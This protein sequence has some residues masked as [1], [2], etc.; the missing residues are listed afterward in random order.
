MRT[1][2]GGSD[3]LAGASWQRAASA[4][5]AHGGASRELSSAALLQK[6]FDSVGD[7]VGTDE[8]PEEAGGDMWPHP[9]PQ[10]SSSPPPASSWQTEEALRA[11]R[12]LA[13]YMLKLTLQI[14]ES[15]SCNKTDKPS[16]L[17]HATPIIYTLHPTP[18]ALHPAPLTP[19]PYALNTK[20]STLRPT[21]CT[22]RP[23]P[24]SAG[25]VPGP[26]P[27]GG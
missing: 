7:T 9:P 3:T 20:P 14:G 15:R 27:T 25:K 13:P 16:T 22:L 18:Y 1:A 6:A 10:P 4:G 5:S 11:G 2:S 8:Q 23:K 17:H 19:A 12:C 21:P 26:R 24:Y